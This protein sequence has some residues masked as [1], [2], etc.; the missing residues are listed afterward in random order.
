MKDR[1]KGWFRTVLP[2]YD[3]R[4]EQQRDAVTEGIL[5]KARRAEVTA[6]RELMIKSYQKYD[7]EIGIWYQ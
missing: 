3:E 5:D 6:R 4:G 2:W 1:F 7:K